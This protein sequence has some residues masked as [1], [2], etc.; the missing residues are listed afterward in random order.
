MIRYSYIFFVGVLFF[1]IVIVA[2][3]IESRSIDDA[4]IYEVT[5]HR[6]SFDIEVMCN[7]FYD[8]DLAMEIRP[9]IEFKEFVHADKLVTGEAKIIIDKINYSTID[10]KNAGTYYSGGIWKK[11]L[12]SIKANPLS[13]CRKKGFHVSIKDLSVD[14]NRHKVYLHFTKDRRP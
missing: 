7:R 10:I 13:L 12:Y 9:P 5:S 4:E 2:A 6:T 3:K 14:L 11:V 1:G 8:I